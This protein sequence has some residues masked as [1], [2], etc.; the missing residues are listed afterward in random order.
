M[1]HGYGQFIDIKG[2]E[3]FGEWNE[4]SLVKY[5]SN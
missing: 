1:R 5:L 3:K 4:D 2:Q